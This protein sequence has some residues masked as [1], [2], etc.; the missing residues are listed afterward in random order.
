[1]N[2]Q[3]E[4]RWVPYSPP[5]Q[6]RGDRA[7][8]LMR[9]YGFGAA[10]VLIVAGFV[11]L[12][13]LLSG[14]FSLGGSAAPASRSGP[15]SQSGTASRTAGTEGAAAP[16]Q[17]TTTFSVLT[18]PRGATVALDGERIGTTP[19]DRQTIEAG[20]YVLSVQLE[21]RPPMDTVVYLRKGDTHAFTFLLAPEDRPLIADAEPKN[22]PEP[23]ERVPQPR[24]SPEPPP[25][26]STEPSQPSNRQPPPAP[27]PEPEARTG[28]MQL[29]SEPG[30]ALVF[31][32]G[33]PAGHTPLTVSDLPVGPHS[34]RFQLQGYQPDRKRVF[35]TTRET[36]DVH[37]RLRPVT[38]TLKVLA[39]PWGSI[40]IDGRLHK[41]NTDVWYSTRLPAGSYRV[42]VI[43][44]A[45]G[46]KER[47]V[48]LEGGAERAIIFNLNRPSDP[49]SSARAPT[50]DSTT[51]AS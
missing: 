38:G 26:P 31:I 41:R 6:T 50:A 34:V 21:D 3:K 32:D 8:F 18:R 47:V 35:V 14:G 30:D 9:R 2:E 15:A 22:E 49:G 12:L 28:T 5:P 19:L 29:T 16:F 43:H 42:K 27:S 25:S 45:L 40:Y 1:M 7:R 17:G 10:C 24:S 51:G 37:G 36:S 4:P 44:P 11:A 48:T 33:E 39:Y 23:V 20:V 13:V 46:T